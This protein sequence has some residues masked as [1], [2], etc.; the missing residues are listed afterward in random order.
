MTPFH[1]VVTADAD[2]HVRTGLQRCIQSG[3][4]RLL[5]TEG[6][7]HALIGAVHVNS[8]AQLLLAEGP[9][10]R[11]RGAAK[12]VYIVPETKPLDDLLTDLQRERST[13]AVVADEYGGT[14]GIVSIEDIIEE[15]VDEIADETDPISAPVRRLGN[16]DWWAQGDVPVR[17]LADYGIE[18]RAASDDYTSVRGLVFDRL[19]RLPKQGEIVVLDGH[20]IRIEAVR[21]N[22][23]AAVRVRDH[24]RPRTQQ[25]GE[26]P[27]ESG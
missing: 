18:L 25:D 21:G 3:H 19:G 26:Q 23:I 2:D 16:G 17:D 1:A 15:I 13:L 8:L 5:V 14:A 4:T 9:D 7:D 24:R 6:A 27:A 12:P 20:S 10:A 11:L 22:R